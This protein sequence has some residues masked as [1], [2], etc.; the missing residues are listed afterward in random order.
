MKLIAL[1]LFLIFGLTITASAQ[2][3][4]GISEETPEEFSKLLDALPPELSKLLPNDLFSNQT[5]DLNSAARKMSDVS[6]LFNA[7]LDT[8]GI[9]LQDALRL[10]AT[11]I[12]LLLLSA[13]L[14][15]LQ[16]T[17]KN[18]SI[19]RVFSLISTLAILSAV[20]SGG[21]S[22]VVAVTQYIKRLNAMT[23]AGIPLLALLYSMGGNVTAAVATTGGLT[24]YLGVL[25]TVVG[26]SIIPFCGVCLAFGFLNASGLGLSLNGFLGTF[27]KHYATLLAFLMM[28]LLAMLASQTALGASA[29]SVAMRSAKFATGN[30]I[31]VVGGSMAELLR[32]VSAGIQYLRTTMGLC[33]I[34]LLLLLLLPTLTELFLYRW[35]WQ[36]SAS[37]AELL[38]CGSE[39]KLL[40]EIASLNGYLI[41]AVSICSSV[42]LLGFILLMRCASAIG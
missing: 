37:A 6:F 4:D 29:D 21:Y 18:E 13:L 24:V 26:R 25:E 9:H 14:S 33:G 16:V 31:P 30:L 2:S 3:I 19:S 36:I 20:L 15:A 11:T 23:A 12:G 40:D 41:A 8:L 7:V 1:C 17:V 42:L 35:V 32:T 39:K 38:N 27:K 22:S 28:L 5:S 34:L 10:L